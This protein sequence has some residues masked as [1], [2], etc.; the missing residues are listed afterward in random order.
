MADL[1]DRAK[2]VALDNVRSWL[3]DGRQNGSEWVAIN[4]TRQDNK[5]GSFSI[6]LDS[7]KWSDFADENAHGNDC[8]SLF[9]YLNSDFVDRLVNKKSY[10]NKRSGAMV[11]AAKEILSRHDVT[12]WP[13]ENDVFNV[14]E[15]GSGGYWAG[16]Y[17]A[18]PDIAD[19][20]EFKPEWF[21][22]K[23]GPLAKTWDFIKSGKMIMKVARFIDDTGKKSDIPFTVW[24]DGETKRWRAKAPDAYI[25]WNYDEL[26]KRPNDDVFLAE[27]QKAASVANALL[28]EHFVCVGWYGGTGS[29]AKT[30]WSILTGRVVYFSFDADLPGRK[31]LT[32]ITEISEK[33]HFKLIPVYPPKGCVAGWDIADAIADGMTVDDALEFIHGTNQDIG[34]RERFIGDDRLFDFKILGYAGSNI[35]FYSYESKKIVKYPAASLAKGQLLTLMDRS[36]WGM[37]FAKDDGGIAWEAA[38][39]WIL[40]EAAAMPEFDMHKIRS[41]GAWLDQGRVILHAGDKVYIDGKPIDLN[42]I[43]SEYMYNKGREIPYS[44]NDPMAVEES[45]KLKDLLSVLFLEHKSHYDIIA[46]YC[47]LAPFC[48]LLRWR[49]HCWIIGP[50]GSG[51]TYLLGDIVLPLIGDYAVTGQGS[52]TPAGIRT[53][54]NG[55]SMPAVLDEMESDSKKKEESIDQI[56]TLL[57]EGSS[58]TD[59]AFTTLHGSSDGEGRQWVIKTQAMCASI[60]AGIKHTADQTR[61][62]IVEM[63]NLKKI[64]TKLRQ[65]KFAQLQE[66][67]KMITGV[68]RDSFHSRTANMLP[69]VLK[70]VD[71][72]C[73]QAGNLLHNQR[74]G[75]QIGTLIAGS[76]MVD[77]ETSATAGEALQY[78][79]DLDVETMI[80]SKSDKSDEEQVIDDI[81]GYRIEITDESARSRVTIGQ[82]IQL[83]IAQS[84]VMDFGDPDTLSFP[85]GSLKSIKRE[86]ESYGIKIIVKGQDCKMYIAHNHGRIQK[87]ILR[88]SPWAAVYTDV[89]KRHAACMTQDLSGP[90]RFAGQSF[91]Y[92]IIDIREVLFNEYERPF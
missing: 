38:I 84:G 86:I 74:D 14:P 62:T 56:L 16:F 55:S 49:S 17:I 21:I 32:R 66:K 52:S 31:A 40:R 68:W 47:L 75:D 33:Y 81:L 48:G 90:T 36:K 23:N 28:K 50:A 79:K 9:Y 89:L 51:K 71:V 35:A 29:T 83:Y 64:E 25:F 80:K 53:A 11:E 72:F 26:T 88:N 42:D 4:P 12:Y 65:E 67:S 10:K 18:K 20:P 54:L 91:R 1:F 92:W 46:G 87:E 45:K 77:H 44:L 61:F 57:R 43:D 27:G 60:G 2:R 73:E 69:E 8:I 30:D 39:N 58:G 15:T 82:A 7:G 37:T 6:N 41:S 13:N 85:G 19:A 78:L 34:D 63:T 22:S 59:T 3:P 76:W 24:T 5:T 70:C